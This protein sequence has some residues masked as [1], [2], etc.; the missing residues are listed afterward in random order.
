MFARSHTMSL[1]S[2]H[3]FLI[4]ANFFGKSFAYLEKKQ[5][6]CTAIRSQAQFI[7]YR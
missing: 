4:Y 7:R 5:Y 3:F 1:Q 2:Y 6:F